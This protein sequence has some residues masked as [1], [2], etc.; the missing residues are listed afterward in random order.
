MAQTPNNI[1]THHHPLT[2]P[3]LLILFLRISLFST[4]SCAFVFANFNECSKQ[5][6][7]KETKNKSKKQKPKT[8]ANNKKH[9][10]QQLQSILY[11]HNNKIAKSHHYHQQQQRLI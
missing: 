4:S 6:K 1:N 3:S 5:T 2:V 9:K 11:N 10:K 7:Q 8:L